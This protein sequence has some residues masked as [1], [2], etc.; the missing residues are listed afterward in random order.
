MRTQR[1]RN[2]V[3]K[4]AGVPPTPQNSIKTNQSIITYTSSIKETSEQ[5][6]MMQLEEM[7]REKEEMKREKE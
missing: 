6:L 3:K 4:A 5:K 1:I 7:K 2:L